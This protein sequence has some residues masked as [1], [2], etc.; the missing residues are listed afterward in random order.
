MFSSRNLITE[1]KHMEVMKKKQR[2]VAVFTI[3][4]RI[5]IVQ[6]ALTAIFACSLYAKE[7]KGQD[8][9]EKSF[10]LTATN[11]TLKKVITEIQRQ[12]KVKFTFSSNAIN[13]ERT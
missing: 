1:Q 11:T 4:M 6:I 12:T 10:N 7:V 3:A 5:T 8:L 13:A 9:L 2:L